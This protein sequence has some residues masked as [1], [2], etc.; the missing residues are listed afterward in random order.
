M[1]HCQFCQCV[2]TQDE[3]H[4]ADTIF[5]NSGL[6]LCPP[7]AE[8]Q[9]RQAK[10]A[11]TAIIATAPRAI[12][13]ADAKNYISQDKGGQSVADHFSWFLHGGTFGNRLVM[14][15]LPYRRDIAMEAYY[16]LFASIAR[17]DK[18]YSIMDEVECGD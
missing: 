2:V 16:E 11:H 9:E 12:Q 8:S 4:E 3:A 6:T 18:F 7:C 13:V 14:K 17:L 5:P 1:P 15:Q 10:E